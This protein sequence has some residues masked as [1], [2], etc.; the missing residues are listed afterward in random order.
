[1]RQHSACIHAICAA[2]T[3]VVPGLGHDGAQMPMGTTTCHLWNGYGIGVQ[4]ASCYLNVFK[5]RLV[6]YLWKDWV[7]KSVDDFLNR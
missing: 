5:R 2:S 6:V 3:A 1:M 4:Q 7:G